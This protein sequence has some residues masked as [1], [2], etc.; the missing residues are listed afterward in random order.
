MP[1]VSHPRI[2]PDV[3]E[4]RA[5]QSSIAD[6]AVRS[7]TLVVLPT[8]LGKTAIALRVAAEY[9][10]REPKQ[11]VL[12]MAPT[13]PLVAQ[14]ARSVAQTLFCPP[15]LVLTGEISPERRQTL[16]SPPQVVVATPQ[17]IANDL[18]E[19]GFPLSTFSLV[20]F[21]EAHR[22][23]GDYP[24]VTVGQALRST[25]ARVLAMTAS[26]GSKLDR[27]QAV[28]ANLGIEHFELR[29]AA[30]AD[31]APYTYGIQVET[32]EVPL[33]AE[34]RELTVLLRTVVQRQTEVL[35]RMG[36]FPSQD[37]SRVELLAVGFTLRREIAAT[38]KRGEN[39]DGRVWQA[40]TAQAVAM[41]A[42]HGL[43]L[44]ETQGVE[45]LRKYLG[46]RGEK[47]NGRVRPS[48]RAFLADPDIVELQHR[49]ATLDLEHPKL[50]TA[51]DLVTKE[52]ARHPTAR[53]ILFAHYR[54]TADALVERFAQIP[55]TPVRAARFVGQASHGTDTG[56]SQ[57][58][59]VD[60]LDRFRRGEVNCL[61]A[62]SVGEEGLDIPS[63][64]LVVFYEPVADEVRTIQR[65]GRTGRFRAGRVIVLITAGTR[66]VGTFL[67]A[68]RKEQ[69]MHEM[70]EKVE[71]QSQKGTIAPPAPAQ[72]QR[73]LDEFR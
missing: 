15:P 35:H 72:V 46:G 7:N 44:A 68:R 50:A 18:G 48:D 12:L 41:K 9:L 20:I 57:K 11:S 19:G 8:G 52:I 51:V 60:I 45:S 70:L 69:R 65:R 2:R 10:L 43:I 6:A 53:V 13:R 59:Q 14:H 38:R 16:L 42:M 73:M 47:K 55:D 56:L 24:Y 22:A 32:V 5:Y 37:A 29:S 25:T 71:A 1:N 27:I 62:T 31:V 4:E 23:V 40:V 21:D 33:P 30:D 58:Q 28:W 67:S 3:L 61:V 39:P 54:Q 64:D 66:D 49:L 34:V 26:P 63:T 36:Y 17:V